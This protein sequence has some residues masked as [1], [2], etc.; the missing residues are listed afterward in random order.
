M[1]SCISHHTLICYG[2]LLQP[3]YLEVQ[4]PG[5][6]LSDFRVEKRH[7]IQHFLLEGFCCDGTKLYSVERQLPEDTYWLVVYD[8]SR[9]AAMDDSPRSLDKVRVRDMSK[10]YQP[11]VDSRSHQVY[12][13]CMESG[14]RMFRCQG[15]RI[16]PGNRRIR[17]V[18]KPTT[19]AVNT[20]GNIYVCDDASGSVYLVSVSE[21]RVINQLHRPA[22]VH[23][24]ECANH[25]SVFSETILVCY[26]NN[27]LVTYSH[28]SQVPT[29]LLKTPEGLGEVSS[30][31]TDGHTSFLLT[32]LENDSLFVLD[33]AGNFSHRLQLDVG[34]PRCCAV[35]QSQIWLGVDDR[36]IA[37][38]SP[39]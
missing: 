11:R 20:A 19:V 31:N 36:S 13:P 24:H 7:R 35:V 39:K 25:V 4:R 5:Q 34:V 37:V 32:D 30:I 3:W 17:C 15:D 22:H 9:A 28:D 8:I 1:S 23:L 10:Y 2:F 12:V 16:L 33:R 14:V 29:Q 18:K 38:I 21:D 27:K 26:G 6:V